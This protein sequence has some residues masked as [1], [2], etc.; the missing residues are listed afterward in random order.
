[1]TGNIDGV[2]SSRIRLRLVDLL[3]SFLCVRLRPTYARYTRALTRQPQCNRV[4]NAPPRAGY[5]RNLILESH[6]D[7]LTLIKI[8]R[9]WRVILFSQRRFPGTQPRSRALPGYCDR[10]DRAIL[11]TAEVYAGPPS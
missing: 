10:A 6:T 7:L 8:Q 5:N 3:R 1:M 4:S 2:C 11:P 9:K